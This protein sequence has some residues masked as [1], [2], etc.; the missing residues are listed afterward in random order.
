MI[1][2]TWDLSSVGQTIMRDD[3]TDV[4]KS[5][6]YKGADLPVHSSQIILQ[7]DGTIGNGIGTWDYDN[8][9]TVTL[10]FDAD[11][12]NDNYEFYQSGDTMKLFVMTG[13]DKDKRESAIIMTGTDQN[14]VASFAKKSNAVPESTKTVNKIETLQLQLQKAQTAI[15]YLDLTQKV[16]L[17]MQ[18]ILPH[19]LRTIQFICMQD[20]THQ[21]VTAM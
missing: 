10:S 2:G 5:A 7:P 9:H 6:A 12:N 14:S 13:Y 21:Q 16:I 19:M 15:R 17:Y 4:S 20:T 8:D 18:A 1:Y 3:V 11:G